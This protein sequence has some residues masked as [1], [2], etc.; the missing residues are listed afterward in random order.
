[1][2][3]EDCQKFII[4]VIQSIQ[5]VELLQNTLEKSVTTQHY[6]SSARNVRS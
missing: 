6:N 3:T 1:M 4:Y 5:E 2:K